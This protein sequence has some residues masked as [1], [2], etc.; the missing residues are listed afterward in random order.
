[1]GEVAACVTVTTTGV[2][3]AT[4]TVMLATLCVSSVLA[5]NVAV[6]VPFPFP[7]EVTVHHDWS[8]AAVQ[9]LFEVTVKLVLPTV[10][11]TF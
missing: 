2:K 6:M 4:V 11:A 5:V 10:A 8:L 9:A 1:M 3:P 7:E